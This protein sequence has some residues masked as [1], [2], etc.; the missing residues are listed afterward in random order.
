[1]IF[2]QP[3]RTMWESRDD[4]RGPDQGIGVS[5]NV[6]LDDVLGS[7]GP[8]PLPDYIQGET[9]GRQPLRRGHSRRHHPAAVHGRGGRRGT[10][11][12]GAELGL[13]ESFGLADLDRDGSWGSSRW[14]SRSI[15]STS[16]STPCRSSGAST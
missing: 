10:S 4:D 7:A 9:L 2:Q 6:K 3:A 15:C 14:M 5:R 8:A 11:G 1:M 13:S 16:C 12:D